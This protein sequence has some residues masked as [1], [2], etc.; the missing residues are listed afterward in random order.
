M[1]IFCDIYNFTNLIKSLT[2]FQNPKNPSCIDL[3][4]TNRSKSFTS[5]Q[6]LDTGLSDHHKMGINVSRA[7]LP[8]MKPKTVTYRSYK[9]F[10]QCNFR[11]E[12]TIWGMRILKIYL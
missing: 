2:C 11:Y 8:K 10:N 5:T 6:V 4:L 12:L 9:K 1:Q 3:M 7:H